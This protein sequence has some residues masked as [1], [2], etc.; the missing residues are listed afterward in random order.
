VW[1]APFALMLA[2]LLARN[3]FLFSAP[4]YEDADMGANS[5]LI[6][7]ARRFTL[8]AGNYSREGFSHPGPAFLYVES[9]A[10]RSSGRCCTSSRPPGTASSSGST[11]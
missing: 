5:I 4:E 1:A 7:Q 6:E 9:W 2:V 11:C 8:L 3:A 10:S